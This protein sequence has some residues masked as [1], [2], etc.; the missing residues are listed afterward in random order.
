MRG[1]H[2]WRILVKSPRDIDVQSYLRAWSAALPAV[3]GDVRIS[4]DIDP[5][6]FL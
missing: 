1:R 4:L 2:R 3:K 6:S 5:Y